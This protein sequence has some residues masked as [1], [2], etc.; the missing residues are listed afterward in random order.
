MLD[1]LSPL[2]III[3]MTPEDLKRWRELNGYSQQGLANALGVFQVSV[4]RWETGVRKIPSFLHLALRCL[5]LEGG[6]SIE[7]RRKRKRKGGTNN[8]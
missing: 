1:I 8:G 5:E 7:G 2:V 4:A 3:L 6:E